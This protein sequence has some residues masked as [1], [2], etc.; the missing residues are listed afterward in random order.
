M[1]RSVCNSTSAHPLDPLAN[2]TRAIPYFAE[3]R[4]SLGN[5]SAL[6]NAPKTP[7][8]G[9]ASS[10]PGIASAH[11]RRGSHGAGRHHFDSH[12]SA[13]VPTT[14]NSKRRAKIGCAERNDAI[15]LHP[16]AVDR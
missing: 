3:G 15:A 16:G 7:S 2:L 10:D 6:I 5:K 4:I 1:D 11:R 9:P 12:R 14:R 13:D 8:R